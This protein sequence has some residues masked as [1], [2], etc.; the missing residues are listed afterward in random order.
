MV[1]RRN[2]I[3]AH[4]GILVVVIRL[5]LDVVDSIQG[6]VMFNHRGSWLAI[7]ATHWDANGKLLHTVFG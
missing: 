6:D 4:E 7:D 1:A 2:G 5:A 3:D